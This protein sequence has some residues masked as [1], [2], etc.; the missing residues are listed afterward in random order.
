MN[1]EL[2][3]NAAG[4]LSIEYNKVRFIKYSSD[5][6]STQVYHMTISIFPGINKTFSWPI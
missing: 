2:G 4:S 3:Q 1:E 6:L 5:L